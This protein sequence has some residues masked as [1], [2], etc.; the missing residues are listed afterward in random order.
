MNNAGQSE[1]DI[2][3]GDHRKL[4][5][6]IYAFGVWTPLELIDQADKALY[7]ARKDGRNCVMTL[8]PLIAV[9]N[10]PDQ[11][12]RESG[13]SPHGR[14][15]HRLPGTDALTWCRGVVSTS[16]CADGEACR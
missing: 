8:D 15:A 7:A 9:A 2:R 14:R 6:F 1:N 10:A 16:I 3:S 11:C 12:D 4:R 5:H 13:G